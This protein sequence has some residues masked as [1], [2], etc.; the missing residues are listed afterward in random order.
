MLNCEPHIPFI[1]VFVLRRHG[2]FL[3]QALLK[4]KMPATLGHVNARAT[5][6]FMFLY[7]KK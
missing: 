6:T 1:F 5:A 7:L 3:V 4:S 2:V